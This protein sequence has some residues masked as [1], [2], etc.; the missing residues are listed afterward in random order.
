MRGV[1]V[2]E[3][4][5]LKS[6]DDDRRLWALKEII[7]GASRV[8]WFKVL[9]EVEKECERV[10]AGKMPRF[11]SSTGPPPLLTFATTSKELLP[12]S[13]DA[14]EPSHWR[15]LI[16]FILFITLVAFDPS[17]FV[18][19]LADCY[20]QH[21]YRHRRNVQLWKSTTRTFRCAL[22]LPTVTALPCLAPRLQHLTTPQPF[23]ILVHNGHNA[24]V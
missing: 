3:L 2:R 22:S 24:N 1:Y 13:P 7:W 14:M 10:A 6:H 23:T 5:L 12:S 15:F 16:F 20:Q 9:L 19:F 17:S 4:T 21:T 11:Y 18:E 8:E